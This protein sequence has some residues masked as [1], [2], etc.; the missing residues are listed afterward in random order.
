MDS[1]KESCRLNMNILF[2]VPYTPNLI[3]SRS[4]NVIRTL[5]ERGNAVHLVTLWSSDEER[6]SVEELKQYCRSIQAFPMPTWRS[7]ANSL[8]ALPTGQPLQAWYSWHPQMAKQI[9]ASIQKEKIDI[10]HVEHL[11]GSKFAL[12]LT[13]HRSNNAAKE[14]VTA[15]VVWDSVDCISYLFRQSSV[16]SKRQA[17]RWIS[18]LELKRTERFEAKL[19]RIFPAILITTQKDKNALLSLEEATPDPSRVN[20]FPIGVDLDYFRPDPQQKREPATLVVS[21]KM[22]YHANVSMAVHLFERIMPQIWA[23]RP[24]AKLWIVGK[25]PPQEVKDMAAHPNVT[26]TGMVPDM[27]T[28]LQR[29][30]VA[31]APL[32][33]GAGMQFKVIENMA[34][35]TPVVASP[36]AVSALTGAVY[37]QDVMVAQEPDEFAE[38]VLRLL[39]D[40]RLRQTVGE[41][42]R[43][44]VEQHFSW[45][46]IVA[47]LEEVYHGVIE[48]NDTALQR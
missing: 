11:R 36:L 28:Y 17:S 3:R 13:S 42:G 46:R 29:A 16:Q 1:L 26:V 38:K 8:I 6:R 31:A 40:A 44:Y 4:Y 35:G 27:R 20:V 18:Q 7:L 32:T 12:Y 5:A 45:D 21:G 15:P 39:D 34:C 24:E 43:K 23:R 9:V 37:D 33:Y 47:N 10:V 14:R 22:S 30:T 19:T 41:A 48:N 2:V 25:D